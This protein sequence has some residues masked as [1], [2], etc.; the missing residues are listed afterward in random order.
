MRR[1]WICTLLLLMLPLM[2]LAAEWTETP[3]LIRPGKSVR[4]VFDSGKGEAEITVSDGEKEYLLRTM[5]VQKGGATL[6]WDGCVDGENLPAGDYTLTVKVGKKSDTAP[7]TIGEEAP[8]ILMVDADE[9]ISDDWMAWVETNMPGTLT[10]TLSEED[11][12]VAEA[13]VDAGSCEIAWDGTMNGT[14]LPTGDWELHFR[15]TDETGFVSAVESFNVFT[16][17]PSLATDLTYHTPNEWSDR[18]CDHEVCF[19]KLPMG[20]MNEEAIWQVLTQPVTVLRGE[21][22]VQIKLRAWPDSECKVYTGEVTCDSQVVHILERGDEWTLVEAYSSSPSGSKVEVWAEYCRGWVKTELLQEKK[23][24]GK[25]GLVVDKLQQRMYVFKD[26][27]WFTTLMISTGFPK[28]DEPFNET[29]AG[30][31]LAVSW[32]GGFWSEKLYCDMGIR[33]NGGT[34]LHEVPCNIIYDEEGNE[35][36]RNYKRCEPVLG[37]KASHGCIRIQRQISPEGVS[38]R[39]LWNNLDRNGKTKVI[40]WDDV[41]RVLGYPDDGL[42]LYYN[43][44][45]GANYHSVPDCPLVA[46]RYLPL[47]AFEYGDIEYD[48][49]H[50]LTRCPGCAP[51]LRVGEID[52]LNEDVKSTYAKIDNLADVH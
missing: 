50:R 47:T 20:E 14:P 17:S 11:A 51:Q 35:V 37:D 15:L 16:H 52:K 27:K 9:Q 4:L 29:P 43:P 42:L 44:D 30:E 32:M 13:Q 6:F 31:Y 23:V 49:Y 19:W 46:E 7:V 24:G 18:V 26:G 12:V 48:P 10:I 21:Q 3:D 25:F 22:R 40:I 2:A 45:G 1:V 34:L 38:M 28:K 39:W 36:E 33:I 8:M 41:G 5:E